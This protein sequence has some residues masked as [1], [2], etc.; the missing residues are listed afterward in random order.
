MATATTSQVGEINP[1]TLYSLAKAK[2]IT[3]WGAQ[4]FR[5][6]RRA[7]LEIIYCGRQAFV[8]GSAII[9][10]IETNGTRQ[11]NSAQR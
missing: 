9:E 6:A 1:D 10:Y 2:Q 4:S 11:K 3:G 8:K 7:G 5:Q